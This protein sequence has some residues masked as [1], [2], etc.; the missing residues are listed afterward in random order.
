MCYTSIA[1]AQEMQEQIY[2]TT[3]EHQMLRNEV[4]EEVFSGM[5]DALNAWDPDQMTQALT[6]IN[7]LF[8]KDLFFKSFDDFDDFMMDQN[9]G[10]L[11]L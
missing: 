11:R 3:K 10:P 5:T 2:K 6:S 7:N 9:S 8:G 1:Q 4:F